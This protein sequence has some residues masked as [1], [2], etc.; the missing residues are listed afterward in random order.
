ME[1]GILIEGE[2]AKQYDPLQKVEYHVVANLQVLWVPM[3]Q[4][5]GEKGGRYN[6]HEKKDFPWEAG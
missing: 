6:D 3:N 4:V 2:C 5:I 1:R